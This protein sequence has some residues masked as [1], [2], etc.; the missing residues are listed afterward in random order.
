M[1]QKAAERIRELMERMSRMEK[2]ETVADTAASTAASASNSDTT[3][4][5]KQIASLQSDVAEA[6]ANEQIY[7]QR[8]ATKE[9]ELREAQMRIETYA[10]KEV[11]LYDVM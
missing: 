5:E 4:L 9:G 7:Q 10:K 8:Y 2:G 11:R 6:K 3:A 1:K